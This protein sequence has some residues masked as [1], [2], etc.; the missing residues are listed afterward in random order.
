MVSPKAPMAIGAFGNKI[1]TLRQ[2]WQ[3]EKNLP[4]CRIRYFNSRHFF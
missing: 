3:V 1:Q 2:T 4:G